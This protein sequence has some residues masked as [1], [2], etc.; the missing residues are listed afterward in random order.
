[1]EAL[2]EVSHS[3]KV[4]GYGACLCRATEEGAAVAKVHG[5]QRQLEREASALQL[6][7]GE[8]VHPLHIDGEP[9]VVQHAISKRPSFAGRTGGTSHGALKSDEMRSRNSV[10]LGWK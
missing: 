10:R 9:E 4:L 5:V 3:L 6:G 1:M 7:T 2:K 8:V